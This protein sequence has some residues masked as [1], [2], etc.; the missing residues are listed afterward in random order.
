MNEKFDPGNLKLDDLSEKRQKEFT[1]VEGGFVRKEAA[2]A[3]AEAEALTQIASSVKGQELSPIDVLQGQANTERWERAKIIKSLGHYTKYDG[4]INYKEENIEHFLDKLPE[5]LLADKN[6][7]IEAVAERGNEA[8]TKNILARIPDRLKNDREFFL[9]IARVSGLIEHASEKLRNDKEIVLAAVG[10]LPK[11]FE[12]ASKDLKANKEV[13]LGA[14]GRGSWIGQVS[15]E[16]RGDKEVALAAGRRNPNAFEAISKELRGDKE[17]AREAVL[18][19]GYVLMSASEELRGDKELVLLAMKSLEPVPTKY[20]SKEMQEDEDVNLALI[21]TGTNYGGRALGYSG[22]FDNY[23]ADVS[24]NLLQNESFISKAMKVNPEVLFFASEEI[25]S[26]KDLVQNLFLVHRGYRNNGWTTLLSYFPDSIREDREFILDCLKK[27][28]E[29]S[30]LFGVSD[31]L[32]GDIS[33]IAEAVKINPKSIE[34]ASDEI[35]K[36][37]KG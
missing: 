16:L 17:V 21:Q 7:L 28:V 22:S 24:K 29:P 20:L 14:V 30:K 3:L 32:K 31:K 6:F 34:I 1:P 13:V 23:M 8:Y 12:Y 36:K 4:N 19:N 5:E 27:G 15:E 33:F 9:E 11:S 26:N 2:Q 25:R 35:K 18:R 10:T 37:V